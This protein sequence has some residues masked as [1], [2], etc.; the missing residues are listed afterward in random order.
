[1]ARLRGRWRY[2]LTPWRWRSARGLVWP[3]PRMLQIWSEQWQCPVARLQSIEETLRAEG[4]AG[5]RGGDYDR[6][7]LEV[8]GGLFGA[9]RLL[10]TTE[11]HGAGRQLVRFRLWPT[12]SVKGV[13]LI[14]CLIALAVGA[15]Y[16]HAW[17]SAALLVLVAILPACRMVQEC[18]GAMATVQH[19]LKPADL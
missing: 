9:A 1:L 19:A 4:A 17:S 5:I 3:W 6:W 13:V 12:C 7:D 8:R 2:G 15:A 14:L 11:E 16:D 18:A 10:A